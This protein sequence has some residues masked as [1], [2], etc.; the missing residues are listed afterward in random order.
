MLRATSASSNLPASNCAFTPSSCPST[1]LSNEPVRASGM[2]RASDSADWTIVRI[3]PANFSKVTFCSTN[4]WRCSQKAP[5]GMCGASIVCS[6]GKRRTY[7]SSVSQK[8]TLTRNFPSACRA[9]DKFA[10]YSTSATSLGPVVAIN[11]CTHTRIQ[12]RPKELAMHKRDFYAAGT[13]FANVGGRACVEGSCI[14]CSTTCAR[15][16]VPV[17][18]CEALL[19]VEIAVSTSLYQAMAWRECW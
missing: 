14:K 9:S 11:L 13:G 2:P 17:P 15:G 5:P 1:T 10:A 12:P 16:S 3:S 8:A 7:D 18:K 4:A 19:D 6:C